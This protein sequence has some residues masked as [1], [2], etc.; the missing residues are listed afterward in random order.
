LSSQW[1]GGWNRMTPKRELKLTVDRLKNA[2]K[3]IILFHD[4]KA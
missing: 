2:G 4:R 1:A 3:E